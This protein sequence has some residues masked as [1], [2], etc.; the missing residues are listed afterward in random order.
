MTPLCEVMNVYGADL[1]YGSGF[2]NFKEAK[3]TLDYDNLGEGSL[4]KIDHAIYELVVLFGKPYF[5][6][7]DV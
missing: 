2:K 5:K 3:M 6:F 1:N 7:Y 4:Y